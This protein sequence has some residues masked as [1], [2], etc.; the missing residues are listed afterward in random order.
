[1]KPTLLTLVALAI[2][3]SPAPAVDALSELA[4]Y[5]YGQDQASLLAVEREVER[6]M[7]DPARQ[8]AM[9]GKL[10]AV[11]ADPEATLAGKQ[12]AAIY[13]RMC[14]GKPEAPA[15]AGMLK[16]DALCEFARGALERIPAPAAGKALRDAL[17][18]LKGPA[19]LGVINSTAN[20][21]DREAVGPLMAL[22]ADD[23]TT[24]R[25]A[26][27]HALGR[28]GGAVATSCL[29]RLAGPDRDVT[30]AHAYLACGFIALEE[31]DR[32]AATAVFDA[33]AQADY[34]APVRRGALAGELRLVAD[35]AALLA[36]WLAGDDQAARRVAVNHLDGQTTEWL[37][38][39]CKDKPVGDAICFAEVLAERGGA[40]ALPILLAAARQ[41]DDPS[42]RIR[43]LMALGRVADAEAVQ[44]LIDALGGDVLIRQAAST[45][46]TSLPGTL[47]DK[48]VVKGLRESDGRKRSELL[49]LVVLR[50]MTG[51]I[52]VLLELGRIEDDESLRGDVSSALVELG[53]ETTL[54]GLVAA[55]LA[56]EDGQHRDRLET[57][58]LEIAKRSDN[59]VK[60]ILAAM[61][62]GGSTDKLLSMLGRVGGEAALAKID[63]ALASEKADRKA[64]GVRALCNWPDAAVADRLA[65][66]AKGGDQP[67]TRVSSLRAYIRVISLE[68]DRP[69]S[70]TRKMLQAAYKLAERPEERVL[71]VKR[72]STVRDM[73]TLR[74]LV[75]LLDAEAPVA[76]EACRSIVDLAHHRFLRN[77]NRD[78]FNNALN[79]VLETSKDPETVDRA[80]GYLEG[81]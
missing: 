43:G 53:D 70:E 39:L 2:L 68:S 78:E 34:P 64:A 8:A 31:G 66:L 51:T 54:P 79:R 11:M 55:V 60:P 63:E 75:S 3:A 37:Q 26:A 44:L 80:K 71:A 9:A 32:A 76:Q 61:T 67:A 15:L 10:L 21:G 16:D 57:T 6:S 81:V 25:L 22:T 35:P 17:A 59:T 18:D 42:L 30:F 41:E 4:D 29:K 58:Y 74:W 45:A 28:I 52:P 27:A 48:P 46:L 13:L 12:H 5:Q 14:G 47:V 40:A 73:E 56:T 49:N 36:R 19:L 38:A 1:M 50:R 33:L 7:A 72:I 20:R 77:P 24:I 62:D 65:A 69:E 23:D